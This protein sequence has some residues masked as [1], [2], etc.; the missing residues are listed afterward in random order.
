VLAISARAIWAKPSRWQV[1]WRDDV[2]MAVLHLLISA[3]P[4]E[5]SKLLSQMK[6]WRVHFEPNGAY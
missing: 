4:R 1:G 6:K 2:I 3:M 5:M